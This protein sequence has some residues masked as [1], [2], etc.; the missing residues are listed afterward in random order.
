MNQSTL[1][2][3][4]SCGA[5]SLVMNLSGLILLFALLALLFC[6]WREG[7]SSPI[8]ITL[9]AAAVGSNSSQ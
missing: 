5:K 8:A 9:D 6:G 1:L 4:R 2:Q 3:L 7:V